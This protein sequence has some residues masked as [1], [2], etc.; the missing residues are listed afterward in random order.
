MLMA[1]RLD[2]DDHHLGVQ[3]PAVLLDQPLELGQAGP[4]GDQPHAIHHDLPQQVGSDDEPGRLGHI[5]ADQQHPP[6]VNAPY[7]L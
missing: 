1:G 3:L 2:A 6:R 5:D 4:V 7:Q